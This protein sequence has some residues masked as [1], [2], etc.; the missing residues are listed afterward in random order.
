MSDE[1]ITSNTKDVTPQSPVAQPSKT[2]SL[3]GK[4]KTFSFKYTIHLVQ[5][6]AAESDGTVLSLATST[7]EVKG[8]IAELDGGFD[9]LK[10][11]VRECLER[12]RVHPSQV[13]DVLTSLSP[14]DDEQHKNFTESH[15]R[16]LF[17]AT[18]ISE[19][20]G[21]MNFHWNYLDPS[22]LEHLVN[23]I[24]LEQIKGQMKA[25]NSAL[26]QFRK[27]TPLRLF[28][29][30]QRRR[31]KLNPPQS[32]RRA[33]AHFD[34]RDGITLEDVEQFRKIY[35]SHYSLHQ[36]AMM[37]PQV[38]SERS[39]SVEQPSLSQAV[40]LSEEGF[41]EQPSLNLPKPSLEEGFVEQPS[42]N[43]PKISS[44]EGFVEQPSLSQPKPSSEE[45][46]VQQPSLN[47]PKPSSE[48]GFVEQPFLSQPKSSSEEEF[49]EQPS[50]NQPKPSSEEDYLF[51]EQP[52]KD[53]FCPVTYDLLLQ[54]H[55]TSCCGMNISQEAVSKLREEK[56]AC[57][58]CA[59]RLWSTMLN[60]HFRRQVKSLH[61][62]CC[63]ED[64]GCEWQGEL[65]RYAQHI[66]DSHNKH[67]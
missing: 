36:C 13:A 60:Q 33:V 39:T 30:T 9:N 10:C 25:Y 34:W 44:E 14:D 37:I 66:S 31:Q 4:N 55:L 59:N 27:K 52:L 47:H 5:Y 51:V 53:F 38:Q 26:Q 22:L 17:R 63:Y 29:Q 45:R 35:A 48:E 50:L 23:K 46:F 19:Q 62:F 43:L 8:M 57:P 20:F 2:Q 65:A 58:L 32:F 12:Q 42:V 40:L 64:R 3:F 67:G 41:V 56:R 7:E 1:G 49:V 24:R 54:P 6:T 11:T 28:C 15:V 16:D 18:N 61:V 21:T